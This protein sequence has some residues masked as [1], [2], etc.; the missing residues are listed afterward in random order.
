M[1]ITKKYVLLT[2]L[3]VFALGCIMYGIEMA[4]AYN[5]ELQEVNQQLE[6]IRDSHIPFLISSL[7]LTH[8]ELLQQQIDAI[9]RFPNIAA[10]AVSDDEGNLYTAG[11]THTPDLKKDHEILTYTYQGQ[12]REIGELTIYIDQQKIRQDV[13]RQESI[14]ILFHSLLAVLIAVTIS[15]L[16]H[17][18]VG[19]HIRY[20]SQ[21]LRSDT[22][23]H[24][25]T[26]FY[27]ARKKHNDELEDLS[28][29]INTMRENIR[30]YLNEKDLLLQEIHHRIKNNMFTIESLLSLQADTADDPK[31]SE[32][33]NEAKG[34]LR[35]MGVLYDRLY[36][37]GNITA[38]SLKEYL[39]PLIRD[40][41]K[42]QT[43]PSS[44]QI[45]TDVDDIVLDANTLSSLGILV[46]ELLTNAVKYAFPEERA[47]EIYISCTSPSPGTLEMIY[48]DNGVGL[49]DEV[50]AGTSGGLGMILVR[51]LTEQLKGDLRMRNEGG[52]LIEFRFEV[53]NTQASYH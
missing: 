15:Y 49:P 40:I 21:F 30:T 45:E 25:G 32:A 27:L 14:I 13:F 47:G 43:D 3:L 48:R 9:E 2:F 44:L 8:Y 6:Q 36:R 31:I 33:L 19:R 37:S 4:S 39:P 18:M 22:H 34:R 41:I 50:L 23:T 16:F 7:W 10:V 5:R 42:L 24:L 11:A 35:S 28:V 38:V 17:T 12:S 46:N 1:S 20:M 53:D 29:S 52:A 26:P 51:S